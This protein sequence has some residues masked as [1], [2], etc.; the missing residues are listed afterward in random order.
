MGGALDDLLP[1]DDAYRELES[2]LV[3]Y[4]DLARKGGWAPLPAGSKLEVGDSGER[5][6]LLRR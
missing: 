1:A 3:E 6:A 2:A 4:R 5:V